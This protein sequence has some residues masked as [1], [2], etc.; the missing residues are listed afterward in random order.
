MIP[1]LFSIPGIV[2]LT[3][4]GLDLMMVVALLIVGYSDLR[5]WWAK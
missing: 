3:I 1:I 5:A 4:I 2:A